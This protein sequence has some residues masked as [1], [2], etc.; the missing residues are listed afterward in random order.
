MTINARTHDCGK[1]YSD[2][3]KPPGL[4]AVVVTEKATRAAIAKAAVDVVNR[5]VATDL[6][7]VSPTEASE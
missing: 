5:A 7:I 2:G 4:N 3:W 1:I 6:D